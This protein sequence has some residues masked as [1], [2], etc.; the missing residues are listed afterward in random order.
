MVQVKENLHLGIEWYAVTD[1]SAP[2]HW[3]PI[4]A[5]SGP[6]P[7]IIVILSTRGIAIVDSRPRKPGTTGRGYMHTPTASTSA[8]TLEMT[9]GIELA[10]LNRAKSTS[11]GESSE[12]SSPTVRV[13]G[14]GGQGSKPRWT[15]AYPNTVPSA[16][17]SS[18]IKTSNRRNPG[19]DTM[20]V[21]G[22]GGAGSKFRPIVSENS[23]QTVSSRV[24]DTSASGSD[25]SSPHLTTG[26]TPLSSETHID[27]A[28]MAPRSRTS[29]NIDI[30]SSSFHTSTSTLSSP[31]LK[32]IIRVGGG[33]GGAGSHLTI[34]NLS[35]PRSS[36]SASAS[37]HPRYPTISKPMPLI[38]IKWVTKRKSRSKLN[39]LDIDSNNAHPLPRVSETQ[40]TTTTDTA[41]TFPPTL[42]ITSPALSTA[43]SLPKSVIDI[44]DED[45]AE[46]ISP[47]TPV[48]PSS[49]RKKK[50]HCLLFASTPASNTTDRHNHHHSPSLASLPPPKSRIGRRLSFSNWRRPSTAPAPR[51]AM[52][53]E[54]WIEDRYDRGSRDRDSV[55]EIVFGERPVTPKPR[56]KGKRKEA[57]EDEKEDEKEDEQ[58]ENISPLFSPAEEE[59]GT[60]NTEVGQET[61]RLCAD[62]LGSSFSHALSP[63]SS[64]ASTTQF[65][66]SESNDSASANVSIRSR[67]THSSTPSQF[68]WDSPP[69]SPFSSSFVR[70]EEDEG[71]VVYQRDNWVGQWNRGDM[72]EVLHALRQLR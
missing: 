62:D 10:E 45:S 66:H 47:I 52:D 40:P 37:L 14:R 65:Y 69:D 68:N 71:I 57:E 51:E 25:L 11:T 26:L 60:P 1:L 38:D 67:S 49:K 33:R 53:N 17:S 50:L 64:I 44:V 21:K 56:P 55:S 5:K 59:S 29:P 72:R 54:W 36:R 28:M 7:F 70:E 30:V 24:N 34:S 22:R 9:S 27:G 23:T 6:G 63:T 18:D 39:K 35:T 48:T 4:K 58:E 32:K 42:S 13:F 41:V 19:R 15:K 8:H 3:E 43:T 2:R 16:A 20:R 31:E 46:P 12:P 61:P